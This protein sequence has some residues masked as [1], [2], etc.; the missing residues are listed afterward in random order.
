M[1]DAA[2]TLLR[3]AASA[4]FDVAFAGMAGALA[5]VS[6]LRDTSSDWASRAARR[7][8]GLFMRANLLALAAIA[9]WLAV[10]VAIVTDL[11]PLDALQAVGGIVADTAFGR[12]WAIATAALA[13]CAVLA[14]AMRY[15]PMP[16]RWL[17]VGVVAAALAHA[18]G[19]HAGAN[20]FGWLLPTMT[21]HLLATSLWAG[22]VFASVL[23]V[24]RDAPA[25]VDGVR[26]AKR[27][28]RVATAALLAGVVTGAASAW[29][30]IGGVPMLL[31]PR[32][33]PW[34]LTLDIKLALATLAVALGGVNRFVVMRALPDA[35]P[36][37][38]RV[39]RVEAVALLAVLVAAAMLASGEP[40]I[41]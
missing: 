30:A 11:P 39:L 18:N 20:G 2:L 28:S 16:L 34:G 7:C 17:G 21:V 29:H 3:D 5:M 14:H 40:P 8:R 27:L 31:S 6:V 10:Q 37:F 26:C 22:A 38:V 41:V 4:V 23:A 12:A 24:W 36:R 33:S 13:A 1:D 32:V 9:A 25:A 19:G 35:W 15:R